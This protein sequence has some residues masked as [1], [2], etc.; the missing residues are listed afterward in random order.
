[1]KCRSGSVFSLLTAYQK[2]HRKERIW[3]GVGEPARRAVRVPQDR[4]RAEH[5]IRFESCPAPRADVSER[6]GPGLPGFGGRATPLEPTR[7][8]HHRIRSLPP[9]NLI[10]PSGTDVARGSSWVVV[11]KA[12]R[13]W[14]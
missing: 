3:T 13:G 9:P 4:R 12:L 5:S 2:S 14:P 11:S 7:P 10:S 8:N 1:M 6:S